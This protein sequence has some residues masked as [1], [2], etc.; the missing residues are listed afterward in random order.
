[1]RR[2]RHAEEAQQRQ[3][4]SG[5]GNAACGLAVH[6]RQWNV[7]SCLPAMLAPAWTDLGAEVLLHA[8][9]HRLT[10]HA[11]TIGHSAVMA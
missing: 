8:P 7:K 9:L 5:K 6:G 10:L 2:A 11:C 3:R 1:M 4:P